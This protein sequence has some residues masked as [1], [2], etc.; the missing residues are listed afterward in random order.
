M[1]LNLEEIAHTFTDKLSKIK[2]VAF[3]VDGILTDGTVQWQGREVEFN[4]NFHIRDGYGF[5]MLMSLGFHVAVISGGKSLGLETR[6]NQLGITHQY[7][8]N[9]DKRAAY[10]DLK[11]KLSLKDEEILY[12]GDELFDIPLLKRAGF[13]ATIE[14]AS[15]E[16][17]DAC[18]YI[19]QT[20]A[21]YGCAREVIDLMR[22]V[23][24]IHPEIPQFED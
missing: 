19:A 8:G 14:T 7:L 3:D 6:M 1:I 23:Q 9:E 21:G 11:K 15:R 13:A 5:R 22:I 24:N 10:N 2:L 4:R 12:M 16:V 18:D 17:R 20:P